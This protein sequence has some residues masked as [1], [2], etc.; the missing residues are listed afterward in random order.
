MSYLVFARKFRPQSFASVVGQEHISRALQ[1]AILRNRIP[2][3]LLFTGPRGVGKTTSARLVAKALNCQK[4]ELPFANSDSLNPEII[5]P[6]GECSNCREIGSSSSIAVWEID[7]ASNNSVDNVR[8]LIESLRS[9]PPPGSRYKIYIIDEVHMLSTAAFN[10]LLKSLEEPPPHTLFIFATTEPHKIPETVISRCQR[11]DFRKLS[12]EVIVRCLKEIADTE[13]VQVDEAVY[14]LIARKAQ[15]GMRDAQSMFDRLLAFSQ[16]KIE[17][18]EAK[19]IFGVVDSSF[20]EAL[21]LAVFDHNP[22]RCFE[23]LDEVFRQSL[24]VRS[25]LGDLVLFWRNL[26]IVSQAFQGKTAKVEALAQNLDITKDECEQLV[27]LAKASTVTDIQRLFDLIVAMADRAIVSAY[28]RYLIEAGFAKLAMLSELKPVAEIISLLEEL[29]KNSNF[30][31]L[32]N[33]STALTNYPQKQTLSSEPTVARDEST[34]RIKK[35]EIDDSIETPTREIS[36]N[37]S[38]KDFVEF[39][40]ARGELVLS[41]H[42]RRVAARSFDLNTLVVEGSGYDFEVLNDKNTQQ[43]LKKLLYAYSGS[44]D[45]KFDITEVKFGQSNDK[46]TTPVL[47]GFS[48]GSI[49]A[50]EHGDKIQREKRIDKEAREQDAVKTVL[51]VLGGKIDKVSILKQ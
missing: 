49:A 39:V 25:F 41:A 45:W 17:I 48:H 12:L 38:W 29:K 30:A 22:Q 13:Q 15:G 43:N 33:K 1:N 7:G 46:K 6:C 9:A 10:A 8:E 50:Q 28:P 37:P 34:T 31:A 11:H 14:G 19:K 27:A 40:R 26:F 16:G 23:L 20:F 4:L 44:S 3:A 21:T 47:N 51:S 24:E 32:G 35:V 18:S 2:H 42:L 5:E 36:F